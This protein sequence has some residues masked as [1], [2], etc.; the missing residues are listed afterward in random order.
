MVVGGDGAL[1]AAAAVFLVIMVVSSSSSSLQRSIGL[2]FLLSCS[3]VLLVVVEVVAIGGFVALTCADWGGGEE[4]V[5]PMENKTRWSNP[6]RPFF[7]LSFSIL[8]ECE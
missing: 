6:P 7:F 5:F 1:A 8:S 3:D 4:Y 2:S